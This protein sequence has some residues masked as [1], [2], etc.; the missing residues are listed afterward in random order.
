VTRMW[1]AR[2]GASAGFGVQRQHGALSGRR[3]SVVSTATMEEPPDLA[4]LRR[5]LG[6]AVV[7]AR[8][9]EARGREAT[10][11][12]LEAEMA[13]GASLRDAAQRLGVAV[14]ASTLERWLRRWRSHGLAGLLDRHRGRTP[15]PARVVPSGVP[16]HEQMALTG[17]AGQAAPS[18][19]RD[20]S[21]K[22]G[23]APTSPLLK[24]PGSKMAIVSKLVSLVP[25]RFER[26]HEPFV[27]GGS[28]FFVLRPGH[29]ILGD[30]NAELV[31]L[32]RVV[33]DEPDALV[34][35]LRGHENTREHYHR[36]RGIHPDALVPVERAART[37]FLNRTCFNGLY[38]VNRHGLFNVPYGSQAHTTFFQPALIHGAHRAL[39][40]VEVHCEDFEACGARARSGD[41][42]YLDPP[43]AVGLNAGR[44]FKYQAGGFGEAEQ[45]RVADLCR[46]LDKRGCLFML[47]NSDCPLTRELYAGFE[48]EALSVARRIGGPQGRGDRAAEIVV[49]N[50][51]GRRGA[52]PGM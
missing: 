6:A 32:Y 46:Q 27:G 20:P 4:S 39:R 35:A 33:R 21:R 34:A 29:A 23:G 18:P 51:S 45:R 22:R 11:K 10:L 17:L 2:P 36:V 1:T 5:Q 43:Y 42:V 8:L 37:L 41:F 31:N 30:R 25:A 50:Y 16:R 48:L 47:S 15:T 3:G 26:Y 49:R 38:R 52:L 9:A 14:P 12:R 13:P 24:W 7:E 40:G 28:L 19:R 44:V